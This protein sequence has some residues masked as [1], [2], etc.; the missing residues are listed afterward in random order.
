LSP[1]RIAQR[2]QISRRLNQSKRLVP[3][4]EGVTALVVY[5]NLDAGPYGSAL[6]FESVR[7]VSHSIN[8]K[9]D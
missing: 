3:Y 5:L 8:H 4:L 6:A 1:V 2:L 9:F 7:Y